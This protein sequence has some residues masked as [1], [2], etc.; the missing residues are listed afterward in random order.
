MSESKNKKTDKIKYNKKDLQIGHHNT[1][2]IIDW[3]DT[4]YPTSWTMQNNIDLTDP[5]S[6]YKYIKYFENLDEHLSSTLQHIKT[7]GDVL[8]IT[9]AMPEWVQLTVSVLPKTKRVLKNV[10]IISARLRQQSKAKMTEWKKHTFL[11]EIIERSR[12]KNYANILSLG[13]AE[14]EYDALI[15]LYKINVPTH[16][17]LKAIKFIKTSEYDTLIEQIKIIKQHIKNICD[18]TRHLDLTFDAMENQ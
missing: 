5:K 9:N 17:Y 11:E 13:D 18:V 14:F 1:I 12:K 15:N 2:I 16:K 7:L 6:R 3:D 10:D 4:L 8:I